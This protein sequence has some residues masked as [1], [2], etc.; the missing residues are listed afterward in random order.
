MKKLILSSFALA[1]FLFVSNSASAQ[2]LITS[3]SVTI[4]SVTTLSI[5]NGGTVS[6]TFSAAELLTGKPLDNVVT[7]HYISNKA[8][9]VSIKATDFSA[10]VG[11][12]TYTMPS[13]IMS[14]STKVQGE[15][16]YSAPTQFETA[17]TFYNLAT[18]DLLKGDKDISVSYYLSPT[19]QADPA[20]YSATITYTITAR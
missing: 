18:G 10:T 4:P 16:D 17:G 3:M 6:T 15:D 1:A 9:Y 7:L 5:D 13:S 8:S 20:A 2:D 12:N 11:A 14:F 19:I